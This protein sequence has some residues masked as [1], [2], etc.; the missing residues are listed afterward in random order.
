[1]PT[2]DRVADA[3]EELIR[4]QRRNGCHDTPWQ[5]LRPGQ[6]CLCGQGKPATIQ[7]SLGAVA[8]L[9]RAIRA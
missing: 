9:L 2:A 1:M 3:I 7:E 6:C 5:P 8:R 4:A